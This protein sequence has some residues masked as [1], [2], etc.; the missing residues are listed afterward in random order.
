MGKR[1][2][3]MGHEAFRLFVTG[4]D[5]GVGKTEAACAVL[6]LLADAG[7]RPAAMKPYESGC[8]DRRQPA[9]ALALKAAARCDDPLD[10]VCLY[11]WRRGWRRRGGGKRRRSPASS[12]SP[13]RSADARC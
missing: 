5:T 13:A 8:L 9:D 11:R 12:P 6:S 1:Y 10:R 4:T 2:V 7:L 3:S